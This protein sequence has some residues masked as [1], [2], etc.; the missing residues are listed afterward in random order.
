MAGDGDRRKAR[1]DKGRLASDTYTSLLFLITCNSGLKIF[2]EFAGG[3]SVSS[4]V[5]TCL[6]LLIPGIFLVDAPCQPKCS[7]PGKAL[8]SG[9]PN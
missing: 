4:L 3:I 7:T 6:L 1:G 2:Y 5:L 8:V 9:P